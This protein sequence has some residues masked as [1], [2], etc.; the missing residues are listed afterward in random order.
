MSWGDK[1][2]GKYHSEPLNRGFV[3]HDP[4]VIAKHASDLRK[5]L[6][7]PALPPWLPDGGPALP[8]NPLAT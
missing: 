4:N 6:G 2:L 8:P 1:W 3:I 5:Q 7:G